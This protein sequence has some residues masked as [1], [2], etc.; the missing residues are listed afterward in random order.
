MFESVVTQQR[1]AHAGLNAAEE[2]EG[3]VFGASV[4]VSGAVVCNEAVADSYGETE[5]TQ[6]TLLRDVAGNPFRPMTFHPGWR[7][8]MARTLAR[9]IYEGRAFDQLPA[10]AEVLERVGCHDPD[11]LGH[12]RGPG[13]HVRGCWAIRLVLG[14]E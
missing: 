3:Y 12:C 6:I 4:N 8:E 5:A 10:L 1:A 2:R 7:S 11:V 9:T 14:R 13:P